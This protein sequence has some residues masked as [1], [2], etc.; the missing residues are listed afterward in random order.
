[1][2]KKIIFSALFVTIT[3]ASY[4]QYT[5]GS[6][7]KTSLGLKYYPTAVTLK[8]H[9]NLGFTM[10]LIGYFW[11]GNRLTALFEKDRTIQGLPGLCWYTGFGAHLSMYETTQYKGQSLIG[12]DGTIGLDYKIPA[13]PINLSIDWQPSFEFGGGADF[14][15]N[16]GGVSVRYVLQ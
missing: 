10:E 16:W 9:S 14:L 5:K 12:I 4:A 11:K 3:V 7:F 1:M 15:A 6:S 8:H 2:I 13:A